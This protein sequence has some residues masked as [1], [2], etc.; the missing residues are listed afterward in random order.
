MGYY[1]ELSYGSK[2]TGGALS[3][4]GGNVIT[5][6]EREYRDAWKYF[7]EVKKSLDPK[8]LKKTLRKNSHPIVIAM[9]AKSPSKNMVKMIGATTAKRRAGMAG[10]R[11]GVIK[12]NAALFPTFSA[13]A[14]AAMFEYG[15]RERFRK[16]KWMGLVTRLVSTGRMTSVPFLRPAWDGLKARMIDNTIRDIKKQVP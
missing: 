14:L 1:K 2:S 11:I 13:P 8:F 6:N 4:R 16:L 9:Q 3:G 12:N 10:V 5:I 7:D 15:T